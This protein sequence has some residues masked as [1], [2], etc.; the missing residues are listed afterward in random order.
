MLFLCLHGIPC[1]GHAR[2]DQGAT[3][4]RYQTCPTHVS[5]L[6]KEQKTCHTPDRPSMCW[7]ALA[8]R[9]QD[10]ATTGPALRL[11][12]SVCALL[13]GSSPWGRASLRLREPSHFDTPCMR[14]SMLLCA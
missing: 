10:S 5:P 6:G 1:T 13:W 11:V 8:I 9:G 3:A 12:A 7:P 14:G 4:S 2:R